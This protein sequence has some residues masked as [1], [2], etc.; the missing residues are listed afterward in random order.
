M[1]QENAE[2]VR[3]TFDAMLRG[4]DEDAGRGFQEDAVWH[5]T[6]VFPDPSIC[7]GPQAILNFWATLVETFR[8]SQTDVEQV[9]EGGDAVVLS[10]H[11]VGR[12]NASG[13]PV[14][15]R[16]AAAF[17]VNDGKISRVDVHGDWAKALEA[18]GL[19]G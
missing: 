15:L 6:S 12:G 16:W 3:R 9:V 8:E 11:S 10:L 5:N 14:D 19:E 2:I 1:S 7:V 18:V 13:V 4:D 17:R